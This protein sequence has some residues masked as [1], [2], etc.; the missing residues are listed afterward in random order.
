MTH[1]DPYA[2]DEPLRAKRATGRELDATQHTTPRQALWSAITAV[3]VVIVLFVVFYG[4]NAQRD[5]GT[6]TAK[7]PA[8]TVTPTTTGQS[9]SAGE[10][11]K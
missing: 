6:P 5:E 4:I 11:S 7:A 9:G 10:K 3:A 8:M 1:R 2:D